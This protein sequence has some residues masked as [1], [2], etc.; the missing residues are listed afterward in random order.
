MPLIRLSAAQAIENR[1]ANP[2]GGW[3]DR[4]SANRVEPVAKPGFRVPFKLK[5]GSKIFTVGS[6][7]ARNVEEELER[8]GFDL[9]MR[10]VMLQ[11]AP[12]AILNNYGTPSIYNEF[13]WAFGERPYVPE[14]QLVEVLPG[15]FADLHLSPTLRPEP[16]AQVMARRQAITD[17][18]RQA[19]DCPVVVMTL[20]LVETWYDT[21]SGCYL[22]VSP[23]PAHLR[24]EPERFEM[25]VLSFEESYDY[26][27]R[28]IQLLQ[29]HGRPDLQMLL[30]VSPVPLG[31]THRDEDVIVA[32]G[33]SKSVLRA[34]AE[35][36][37]AR[38]DFVTYYP[39]YESVT[40]SD[41]RR[42]WRD[43]FLHVAHEMVALNVGRMVDAFIE[44][45]ENADA[46]R[47]QVIA[48]GA[49]LAVDKAKA[50]RTGSRDRAA[51]FFA[52]FQPR[53]ADSP[54][55]VL[56]HVQFLVDAGNWAGALDLLERAP[57]GMPDLQTALIRSQI[58]VKLGRAGEAVDALNAFS[59]K[60]DGPSGKKLKASTFW[61]ALLNAAQATGDEN[62]VTKV[63]AR[64][65]AA[66]P[67]H[68]GRAHTSVGKW[69]QDRG[70][71][72]RAIKFF[73]SAIG[74]GGSGNQAYLY[75]AEALVVLG[76]RD[77][78]RDLLNKLS[79]KGKGAE[80]RANR[81][82]GILDYKAGDE[83]RAEDV[84]V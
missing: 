33:Y 17:A 63:L 22:N 39:S 6:C 57:A 81:L 35:T 13:A 5:P 56:E 52:E 27:D 23:R 66:L 51:A 54:E 20:G 58:L 21:R 8:R 43:D 69:F 12:T 74:A 75:L 84:L 82:A 47:E 2:Y 65:L 42:A 60:V 28:T 32:N 11:N 14:D 76:R 62:A 26:L 46:T 77:E 73:E 72:E 19:A 67:V 49:A 83:P 9:P 7:F 34:V 68:A 44:S 36:L 29:K 55:F 53:F 78:A 40:L 37:V 80:F 71:V 70:D 48:G 3:G 31:S 45:D 24:N 79:P 61:Y 16:L 1:K 64:L 30:T 18:Y 41:R 50:L 4:A 25:H 59:A 38:Y 10:R 15:K